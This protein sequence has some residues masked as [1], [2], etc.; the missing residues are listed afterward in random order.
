MVTRQHKRQALK[1]S[2]LFAATVDGSPFP[3][4]NSAS[5]GIVG[6]FPG[7]GQLPPERGIATTMAFRYPA[8]CLRTYTMEVG[9]EFP[10][11]AKIG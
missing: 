1:G 2:E 4:G 10:K 3:I 5:P 8:R 11:G 7:G 6:L 9:D